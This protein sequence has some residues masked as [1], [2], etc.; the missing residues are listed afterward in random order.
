MLT[1]QPSALLPVWE[2]CG[3]MLSLPQILYLRTHYV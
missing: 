1:Q 3:T 2:D